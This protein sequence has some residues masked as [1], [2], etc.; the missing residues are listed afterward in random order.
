MASSVIRLLHKNNKRT[1]DQASHPIPFS[2]LIVAGGS[3]TR[4][5]GDVPKQ[6]QALDDF[7]VLEQSIIVFS[8]D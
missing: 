3:G 2:A 5:G 1:M 6:Y 8:M 7:S 4:L